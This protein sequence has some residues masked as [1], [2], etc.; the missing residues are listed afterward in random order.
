M[1]LALDIGNST[2][3]CALFDGEKQAGALSV[4][5]TVQRNADET[6]DVIRAFLSEHKAAPDMITGFGISSVVPFLTSLFSTLAQDRLNVEPVVVSGTLD[7]GIAIR[8]ADPSSLGS[9]RICSAIAGY[10]KFGGPLII[11]DFGTA[12]T[13]GVVAE[14]GDFLGGA[15]SLGIKS[16]A[17]ALSKRTAQLPLIEL[18]PPASAICTD[19]RS[20]IQAGVMFSMID[21]VEGMIQRFKKELGTDA[22]VVVTGGLSTLISKYTPIV[23]ACEPALVLEGIR[24]IH[25][26]VRQRLP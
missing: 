11:V 17:D 3:S 2:I 26:R 9:D 7:L 12:T 25:E 5:S 22:K 1:L 14:N 20:A 4:S 16:T 8:Y 10:R 18:H 13:Y 23:D 6:W 19:T 21:A 24:L 15:I